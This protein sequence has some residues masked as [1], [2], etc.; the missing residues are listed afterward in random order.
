[1]ARHKWDKKLN[2]KD[3]YA[4]CIDCGCV[5]QKY[6]GSILYFT[7][8]QEPFIKA[9]MCNKKPITTPN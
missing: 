7:D 9:P 1:M 3:K 5:K 2:R 4:T 6:Y 8:R